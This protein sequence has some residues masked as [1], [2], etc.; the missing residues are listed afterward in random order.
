[1]HPCSSSAVAAVRT[2]RRSSRQASA[3]S[4][5]FAQG[6]RTVSLEE[7]VTDKYDKPKALWEAI[8]EKQA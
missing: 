3:V 6:W 8:L 4:R 7:Q 1:M 2:P 5:L